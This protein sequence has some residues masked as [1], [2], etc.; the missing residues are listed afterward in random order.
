MTESL[1]LGSRYRL[2]ER[3]GAGAMGE[4]WRATDLMTDQTVAAKVLHPH[5]ADDPTFVEKF[6]RERSILLGLKHP[7]IVQVQDMVVEGKRLAILMELVEGGSLNQYLRLHGTLPA[8]QAVATTIQVL[9]AVQHAHSQ[10]VLHRDIKPDNVLLGS[11]GLSDVKLSDFGVAKLTGSAKGYATS[12]VGTPLYMPPELLRDAIQNGA[13]DIYATGTLLYELLAGIP[14][15]AGGD[16]I[17]TILMRHVKS[18]PPVLPV[19]PALWSVIA[20]ML[21][22]QPEDRPIAAQALHEL[23]SLPQSALDAPRLDVQPLPTSWAEVATESTVPQTPLPG[24]PDGTMVK[25]GIR[26]K[27]AAAEAESADTGQP[28]GTGFEPATTPGGTL[29]GTSKALAELQ[30]QFSQAA[31]STAV[32]QEKKKP[33][34]LFIIAGVLVVGL[35]VFL[36]MFLRDDSTTPETLPDLTPA[37]L[38][39]PEYATGLETEYSASTSEG[40]ILL[41]IALSAPRDTGLSGEVLVAFPADEDGSCP[42][43]TD[44]T[45]LLK[46][47]LASADGIDVPCAFKP[48]VTLGQGEEFLIET[49]VADLDWPEDLNGWLTNLNDATETALDKVTGTG[50]ALQRVQSITAEAQSVTSAGSPGVPYHVF[51]RFPGDESAELFSNTT[52]AYQATDLLKQLTGGSGLSAVQLTSC[53]EALVNGTRVTAQQP[54]ARCFVR[55]QIGLLD[56]GEVPFSIEMAPS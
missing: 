18:E 34:W 40:T 12:A 14:P 46:P 8:N 17:M 41:T 48:A 32:Q 6:V 20:S 15:F 54:A 43:I 37:R 16:E 42:T 51:A 11:G 10:G 35:T 53:N 24:K 5:L 45:N 13:A 1:A 31:P 26:L 36:M 19:D 33:W 56:T 55:A 44:P 3:I 29:L 30:S 25:D 2:I 38:A 27:R 21:A 50:F 7:K 28:T 23:R 49:T 9:E 4:V 22:K 52:L 39:G 47:V